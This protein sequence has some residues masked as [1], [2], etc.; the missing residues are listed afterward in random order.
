M[1]IKLLSFLMLGVLAFG[2]CTT[3]TV[4]KTDMDSEPPMV[5]DFQEMDASMDEMDESMAASGVEL[6]EFSQA[7]YDSA[8]AEGKD[9]FLDFYAGWCPTCIANHPEIEAALAG[10]DAANLAA[11]TVD[12]DNSAELQAE[13]A[14]LSQSTYVLIN[15]GDTSDYEILGPGLLKESDFSSFLQ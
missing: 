4:E 3:E 6:M 7:A 1:Q 15:E 10:M 9:V 14:V 8:L 5:E 11:F 12:Y 13:F 2:A